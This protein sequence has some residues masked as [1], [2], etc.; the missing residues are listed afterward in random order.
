MPGR[1]AD[2]W[3]RDVLRTGKV[4]VES[5]DKIYT[6]EYAVL[7]GGMVR[8]EHGR[9]TQLGGMTAEQLARM[10]L[11]EIVRSGVADERGLGHSKK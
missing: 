2:R 6:A 7:K 10:L 1:K 5:E 8:L 11:W 3:T 4:T 9:A